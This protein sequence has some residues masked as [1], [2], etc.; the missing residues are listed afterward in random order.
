MF[1]NRT[2]YVSSCYMYANKL[3]D[4]MMY[5]PIIDGYAERGDGDEAATWLSQ[6]EEE[7]QLG[8]MLPFSLVS[9]LCTLFFNQFSE[10]VRIGGV[11]PNMAMYNVV[12]LIYY[13]S[14]ARYEFL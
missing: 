3:S 6:A 10:V 12:A 13:F 11:R 7:G 4:R 2:C 9:F 1:F 14:A 5:S 8:P